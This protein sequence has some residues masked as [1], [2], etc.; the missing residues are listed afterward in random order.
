MKTY[1]ATGKT[2]EDALQNGLTALGATISDV[3]ID[4]LEEGSKGLFG[5]FG[6][7]PYKLRL[8]VKEDIEDDPLAD[9]FAKP[10]PKKPAP[11]AEKK[12]ESKPVQKAEPKPVVKPE[13]KKAEAPAAEAKTAEEKPAEE[14][15]AAPKPVQ[16]KAKQPRTDA[17][18]AD[19]AE[20]ADNAEKKQPKPRKERT[21]KQDGEKKAE[22]K[23]EKK[24]H[25]NQTKPA[26]KEPVK[27]LEKPVVTMIPADQVTED[28]AAGKAQ[29]FL[30]ELTHLMGVD[31]EVAVGTD[32]ENNVFV[33]MTGDTLGILIGRRGETLDALQYLTSLKVNR[34]QDDY[35]RVTLDTENYRAK[36]EDTL[37]RL[38]NR[39]ANRAVKTGR[40]VSLE[41]MN[42]YERRIIHSALQ[43]N[44]AVD[45][46]SEGEEP[47]RH[48]VITLRK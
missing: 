19:S 31:V 12:P 8:T 2:Y 44:D 37:I 42:P 46:H 25:D 36:R 40:K 1:E 22:K 43:A 9:L 27:P 47:N 41:P 13:P 28:S 21:S 14:K 33:Q 48:V 35:T 7:R 24:P 29:A 26:P 17:P 3:T 45:T 5:L 6:S 20:K 39:M 23:S 15:P 16:R 18:K 11:R 38:A 32:T 30:K 10:E 34:G 4:V